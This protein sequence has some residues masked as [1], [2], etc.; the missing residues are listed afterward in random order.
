MHIAQLPEELLREILRLLLAPPHAAFLRFP[1]NPSVPRWSTEWNVLLARGG[2]RA[3]PA[4]VLRVCKTWLRVGTPLLYA[5]VGLWAPRHAAAVAALLV[6]E[7][8]LGRMVRCLRLEGGMG[9]ELVSVARCAPNVRALYVSLHVKASESV[10]GLRKSVALLAPAALYIHGGSGNH[11]KRY[12]EAAL[13]V[14]RAVK[15]QWKQSL[16]RRTSVWSALRR[17]H[18]PRHTSPPSPWAAT[19][20]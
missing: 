18:S 17:P 20:K 9:K 1:F 12:F 6:R 11:N 19:S 10:V 3:R 13:I 16:V 14:E 15:D 5:C 7:T 8:Q 2:E 4:G